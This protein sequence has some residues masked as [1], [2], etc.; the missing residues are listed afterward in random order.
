MSMRCHKIVLQVG[1]NFPRYRQC[2]RLAVDGT[3][4]CGQ[5]SPEA[6]EKRKEQQIKREEAKRKSYYDYLARKQGKVL[7]IS[8]D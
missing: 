2:S 7:D 3:E 6:I 8:K 5:H 1:M 4:F